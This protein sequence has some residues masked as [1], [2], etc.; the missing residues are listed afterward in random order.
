VN[1]TRLSLRDRFFTP[2]VARAIWSPLSILL[3]GAATAICIAVGLPVVAAAAIGLGLYSAKVGL[4]SPRNTTTTDRIDPFVLR[5][6]WRGYVLS[7]QSAKLRFDRTVVGTRTGPIRD[8]LARVASRL[9]DGIAQSWRIAVRGNDIDG[10]IGQLNTTQAERELTTLRAQ[11]AQSGA[12]PDIESTIRSL[13][14]QISSGR[15]MHEV[16]T[17]TRNPRQ[18]LDARFDELVAR[19]VEVSV[20]SADSAVLGHDVDDLVSDLEALRQAMEDTKRA[21]TGDLTVPDVEPPTPNPTRSPEAE[22]Q[23]TTQPP[24]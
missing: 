8:H 18:L 17:S 11:Q 9:D 15:R 2:P 19:A 1:G 23:P 20:G 6:P 3:L 5:D 14:A 13:E 22:N 16:S 7:A 12:S 24:E 4:S 10:A 21:E